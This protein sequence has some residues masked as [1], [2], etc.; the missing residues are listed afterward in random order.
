MRNDVGLSLRPAD[1][2]RSALSAVPARNRV[3][4]RVDGLRLGRLPRLRWADECRGRT[5]SSLPGGYLMFN[6]ECSRCGRESESVD[7]SGLCIVCRDWLQEGGD[8]VE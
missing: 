8:D 6:E 5:L 7:D 4:R 2:D 3:K 1:P